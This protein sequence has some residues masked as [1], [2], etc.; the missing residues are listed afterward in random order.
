[1]TAHRWLGVSIAIGIT[2]A[3]ASCKSSTAP[4][5]ASTTTSGVGGAAGSGGAGGSSGSSSGGAG[6]GAD[7]GPLICLQ[8]YTTIA[9]GPCDLLQQDCTPG[10]TCVPSLLSNPPTTACV[11]STGLKTAGED[12]YSSAE[13]DAKLICVGE[14]ATQPGQ[15]VA[16]CCPAEP[17][18]PCNGGICNE[19]VN[20]GEGVLAYVCSYAQ[21]CA[22]LTAGACPAGTACY[23]ETAAGEGI[24]VCLQP[25]ATVVG[26]LGTC[27]FINDC[28]N[29]QDC[30]G[31]GNSEG[32]CLY[33][34]A[35]SGSTKTAAPGLGGCPS[36]QS[37]QSSYQGQAINVG[38]ANIG[39]CIPDDGIIPS[40]GG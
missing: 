23:V 25:S 36:G 15:C 6:G 24:A 16:F 28:E 27:H 10:N 8:S 38:V 30:F 37:C 40:D 13:C 31:L 20:F 26:D 29:M 5:S 11:G 21:R 22:L 32:A 3:F 17:Y 1:M 19:Q 14:S 33:Y 34:C 35:L 9:K 7:A 2:A 12:C 18:Q 4:T 39:V